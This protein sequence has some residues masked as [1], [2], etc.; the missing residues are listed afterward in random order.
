MNQLADQLE[1]T[2]TSAEGELRAV[3]E[4]KSGRRPGPGKWSA[5]EVLGHLID[6]ASNNHGRFVRGALEEDLIFPGYDQNQWVTLQRYHERRWSDLVD[7]WV[8]SNLHLVKVV[9]GIS[10]E[11]LSRPRANHN[12]DRIA[13]KFVPAREPATLDY[14]IDDYVA[15]MRH[16][17]AQI[18][19]VVK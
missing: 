4:E 12:F 18:R 17:L 16:H 11:V 5:R 2:V 9:A 1:Q 15:H 8:A 6:S 19:A 14:F 10:D 13:W 7:L 3:T